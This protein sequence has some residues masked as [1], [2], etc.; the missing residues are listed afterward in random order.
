MPA[1]LVAEHVSPPLSED[2]YITLKVSDNLHAAL[3]P[4]IWAVYLAH[5]KSDYLKAG[6]ALEARMLSAAGL[7][8]E[9]GGAAGR[10]RRSAFFTPI[11]WFGISR[12]CECKPWYRYLL[13]GLPIM[14]VDGT[15]VNIQR[16]SPARGKV[17]AKTGTDDGTNYLNGGEIVE[18]G[19]AGYI[20][21]RGGHH[22][23]FAFY[24]GAMNGPHDEDTGT[25][26]GTD[27]RRDGRRDVR[28]LIA[29]RAH[30]RENSRRRAFVMHEPCGLLADR[31]VLVHVAMIDAHVVTRTRPR[32]RGRTRRREP[33]SLES[34]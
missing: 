34:A 14:G 22:V 18:K 24:I 7:D 30:A 23:A 28:K 10:R 4:Y 17:F 20:T 31:R 1:N 5:A 6:F 16:G 26:A 8:V 29:A 15:L 9:S 11:S 21:T 27:P 25:V 13:R 3:M 32:R 33:T 12:G 19:L 2:A